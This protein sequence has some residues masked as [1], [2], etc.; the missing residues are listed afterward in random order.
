MLDTFLFACNTVFPILFLVLIGTVLRLLGHFPAEARTGL[1]RIVFRFLLPVLLFRN[2]YRGGSI[3]SSILVCI[4]YAVSFGLVVFFS[5]VLISKRTMKAPTQRSILLMSIFRSNFAILGL[6][7]A[8]SLFGEAGAQTASLVSIATIPLFNTLAVLSLT[9]F[10]CDEAHPPKLKTV[11]HSI[12]TNPLILGVL[13]GVAAV[14]IR[15]LFSRAGIDFRLT[16]IPGLYEVIDT[17]AAMATSLG[18]LA[19]GGDFEFAASKHLAKPIAIGT[20]MRLFVVPFCAI[21][22]AYLCFPQFGGAEFATLLALFGTPVAISCVPMAAEMGAD[23]ELAGQLVVWSAV[24]S[25]VSLF[26]F[27]VAMRGFGIF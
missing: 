5:G 4:A 15:G 12:V 7:L 1:N 25:I 22:I 23:K 2:I 20:V 26:L 18:L 17:T 3:N 6:P 14:L 9:V 8:T 16:D 19:L 21:A 24:V 27:I 10:G 13:S 11:L